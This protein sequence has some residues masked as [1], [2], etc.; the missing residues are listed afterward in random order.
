[1]TSEITAEQIREART[2]LADSKVLNYALLKL[3]YGVTLIIPYPAATKI[4]TL[5]EEAEMYEDNYS[6]G[7]HILPIGSTSIGVN[8]LSAENYRHIKMCNLLNVNT[9][10]VDNEFKN[11]IDD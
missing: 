11:K 8:L 10:E 9:K 7:E 2:K 6:K 4:L 5:I 1:M 3:T